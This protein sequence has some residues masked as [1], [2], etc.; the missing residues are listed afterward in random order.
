MDGFYAVMLCIFLCIACYYDYRFCR[1][2]NW[3]ILLVLILGVTRSVMTGGIPMTLRYVVSGGILMLAF[4]PLF[5]IGTLGGGDVKLYGVCCGFFPQDKIL[6]FLFFSLLIAT[7]FSLIRF[8]RRADLMDR[9]T[10]L[11]SYVKSV[12]D[13]GRW[14]LY[15]SDVKERR[16]A[17]ICLAGPILLSVLL[18]LGGLY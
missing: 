8:L 9:L 2:P 3:L 12:A 5:R 6:L 18:F 11:F 4:Y 10:Y 15:L 13:S 16:S 14:T 1:I 7:L 17:G